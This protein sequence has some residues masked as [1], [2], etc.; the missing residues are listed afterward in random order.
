MILPQIL[1]GVLLPAVVAALVILLWG[2][3]N[4]A[5]AI[6]AGVGVG[7]AAGVIALWGRPPFPAIDSGDWI[8]WFA[9]AAAAAAAI[10][11]PARPRRLVDAAIAVGFALL[12]LEPFL[13]DAS[14]LHKTA[15]IAGGSASVLAVWW[16]LER[17]SG[18]AS[19]RFASVVLWAA[20]AAMSIALVFARS[21]R[22]GQQ[23]G[24]V[25]AAIGAAAVLAWFEERVRFG[26]GSLGPY[27]MVLAGVGLYGIFYYL[28]WVSFLLIGLAP[29]GAFAATALVQRRRSGM[30]PALVGLALEA[31]LLAA[32][33][34]IELARAPADP[35]Y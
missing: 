21:A 8:F 17:L 15:V 24:M 26:R 18:G 29:M 32:A 6:A 14:V 33:V 28:S 7:H 4:A 30:A 31:L 9:L 20:T 35:I 23:A 2:R 10:P 25:A 27:A 1:W 34:G 16:P 19:P 3:R 12:L 11:V 22:Q 5:A 13:A